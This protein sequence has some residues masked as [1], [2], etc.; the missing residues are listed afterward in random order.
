MV[1]EQPVEEISC[2]V[3]FIGL[4]V[5]WGSRAQC[6]HDSL[7]TLRHVMPV[8]VG[9]PDVVE[10]LVY[11]RLDARVIRRCDGLLQTNDHPGLGVRA[12]RQCF[13]DPEVQHF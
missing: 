2:F 12:L 10:D 11:Q 4:S 3:H 8:G 1:I 7:H 5:H 6:S 13:V 9:I